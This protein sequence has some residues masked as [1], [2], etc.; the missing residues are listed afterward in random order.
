MPATRFFDRAAWTVESEFL[1]LTIL[2]CGG[3]LAEIVLKDGHQ[4]NPLWV[5]SR[6]TIDSDAYDPAIHGSIYGHSAESRLLSGLAGH[7]LCFPFW[8]NPTPP[9]FAAGMTYHGET[10][11]CR[12]NSVHESRDEL[13]LEVQL[14]ESTMKVQR[15]LRCRG[16]TVHIDSR[17]SNLTSWDR[18]FGWCE[19]VTLGPPF[20]QAGF[21][22]FDASLT[23][24][25]V[26]GDAKGRRLVWPEGFNPQMGPHCFDLTV[27]SPLPHKDLVNSFLVEQSREWGFF[28]AFHP[29]FAMVFGYAFPRCE[30]PWLNVWE[31]NDERW[32]ARGM[33]FSN[34]PQ[35][36]TMKALISSP[37][38]GGVPSYEWLNARST[39]SKRFIAFMHP[40]PPDFQGTADLRM[41]AN[42][43]E[44]VERGTDRVFR[45]PVA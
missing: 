23:N 17:A 19:H 26:T 37:E 10:N 15:R 38:V 41:L 27:F 44:V 1:R 18:A 21:T 34:T 7:N 6:P 11:I 36:G 40:V 12:W 14:P 39:V 8:G 28:T 30:F 20:V 13:T 42:A 31:N 16:H 45:V 32:Q 29:R 24:G 5:Q 35:H 43:L 2:Q 22:R 9:E 3:H 25:F 33:E 4:I